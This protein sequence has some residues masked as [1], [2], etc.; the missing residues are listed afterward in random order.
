MTFKH[1]KFAESSTMQ[2]FEKLARA[3]GLVK[4]DEVKKTAT[5]TLDL[6]PSKN[7]LENILKLAQGLRSQGFH[8]HADDLENKFVVYKRAESLYE[9]SK[10]TGEDMVDMAHPKGS[11]KMDGTDHTVLTIVDQKKKI[12]EIVNKK[13]TGKF[14]S[15]QEIIDTVKRALGGVVEFTASQ[16]GG[17]A[18]SRLLGMLRAPVGLAGAAPA[19][20]PVAAGGAA[21]ASLAAAILIGLIGG[22]ITGNYLF[23]KYAAPD[24]IKDAGE[25]LIAKAE[26]NKED[27]NDGGRK[28]LQD[29]TVSFNRMMKNYSAIEKVKSL[30]VN[31][32]A[33]APEL[34]TQLFN[35]KTLDDQL[36][37][38]HKHAQ[39]IW[40]W[41]QSAIDDTY[42]FNNSSN[43]SWV[44]KAIAPVTTL[45]AGLKD[46]VALSKNYMDRCNEITS[47]I[48]KFADELN[49]KASQKLKEQTAA[50]AGIGGGAGAL[51]LDKEYTKALNNIHDWTIQL[52]EQ[53]KAAIIR[54]TAD[55]SKKDLVETFS[56]A[57]A[58]LEPLKAKIIS[59]QTSFNTNPKD[60]PLVY[61]SYSDRFN[62]FIKSELD[63]FEAY[64]KGKGWIK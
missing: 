63:K 26:A 27:L 53:K 14:A 30:G 8:K 61:S 18:W 35:L 38:T 57:T 52:N 51:D 5:K 40:G 47:L 59:E 4:P 45:F 56:K 43:K 24:I 58:H 29:F 1:L 6:N 21:I 15:N 3:K 54:A 13:S 36:W 49:D 11:K 31:L 46:V 37:D 39:A 25:K 2:A 20:A 16:L 41:A 50:K 42:T 17:S 33:A 64:V 62:E 28:A 23:D 12:E 60:K 10:E 7:F 9:T 32:D 22:I 19:G 48:R 55:P 44:G 34:A